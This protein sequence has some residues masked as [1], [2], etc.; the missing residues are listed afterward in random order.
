MIQPIAH[1]EEPL[2]MR[3]FRRMAKMIEQGALRPGDRIASVRKLSRQEGVSIST[4]LQAYM[5]LE[6]QGHIE[7]RPQS[8]FYVKARLWR[9]PAEPAMSKPSTKAT[10]VST[11]ELALNILKAVRD[12]RL[13]AFGTAIP[14]PELLPLQQLNRMMA[15]IGRRDPSA[16][17]SY[18]VPPGA[19]Q[20]RMQVARLALDYGCL[21]SP[22]DIVT[23]TGCQEALN[24]CLRAVAQPGDTI[25]VESP[26]Y[27]GIL[28]IV[29]AL[30]MKALEIPTHPRDGVSLDALE[31]ALDRERIKACLFTPT[32][33]NPLGCSMPDENRK[34]LVA[35]LTA[36]GIPLI[37][38]DIYGD[39]AFGPERP[40]AVKAYDTEGMVLLCDSF[41]KTLAPGYRV[42]WCAPGRYQKT[43]EHLKFTTSIASATLPALAIAEFLATG[44]YEHHLRRVRRVYAEQVRLMT[45]VI[46]RGFPDGTKVTRPQGGHVL[47]VEMPAKIDSMD[48]FHRAL[49]AKISIAPGILFSAKSKYRNCMR[50]NCGTPW[51][52]RVED[53]LTTLG[54]LVTKQMR[55]G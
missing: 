40:R 52:Q 30:G 22:D 27:Y 33:Q 15:S 13:V 9:P 31:Y 18:D 25:A 41:S 47:W 35:M 26:T 16:G 53:A 3:I 45:E 32:Y 8:G 24:L 11:S 38:D 51:G 55:Q 19:P 34:R 44:G 6:A 4:V 21:L 43:V 46:V 49:A 42:G 50:L 54:M 20:L 14:S 10:P 1:A 29:G 28:Q 36:R 39:I 7:A 17:N 23:T 37:E 2:Y 12:P 5:Q 48:L